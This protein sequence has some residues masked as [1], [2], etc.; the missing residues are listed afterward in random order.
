MSGTPRVVGPSWFGP[1]YAE[2][3]R[4]DPHAAGSIDR[5]L[6]AT[7][8]G[9]DARTAPA[10]YRPT[11][12][13]VPR[14]RAGSRPRLE[15]IA[16]SVVATAA[17]DEARVRAIAR[18]TAALG[19]RAPASL[20]ELRFGGT[21]E[22]IVARG[23]DWCTDVARVAAAL[24]QVAGIPA[25]LVQLADTERPYCGHTVIEAFRR[26]RWG[27]VDALTGVVYLDDRGRPAST[28]DLVRHPRWVARHGRAGRSTYSRV[29][30]F[31]RCAIAH[32]RLLPAGAP[33][34]RTS[35]INSYYRSILRMSEQ[36]WPGGLRWLHGEDRAPSVRG[37]VGSSGR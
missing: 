18:F 25:R 22:A 33:N 7:A 1:R 8:V 23:S 27:C 28:W 21:E 32:Y 11:P 29:G 13:P 20:E 5:Q 34:Y 24:A 14:Y 12:R 6:L 16:R 35:R 2:M 31:R 10:L 15:A 17:G 36:G 26:G 37:V 19:E 30:Q 9:L 4:H 3:M